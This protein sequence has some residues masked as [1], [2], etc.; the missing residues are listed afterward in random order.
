L[1]FRILLIVGSLVVCL[2]L[3]AGCAGDF[4]DSADDDTDVGNEPGDDD[5]DDDN[6]DDDNNDDN[7]DD[8]DD[9]TPPGCQSGEFFGFD[10]NPEARQTPFPSVLFT[11]PAADSP[12]GV[13]L[14]LGDHVTTFLEDGWQYSKWVLRRP[15]NELAG[16]SVSMPLWFPVTVRPDTSWANDEGEPSAGDPF[17]CAALMPEGH[18]EHGR[19]RSIGFEFVDELGVLAVRSQFALSEETTYACVA[20]TALTTKKGECYE[21]PPHLEYLLAGEPDPADPDF[22]LLE[23]ERLKLAPYVAALAAQYGVAA[24]E[25]VALTVFPTQ[26]ITHDLLSI[27][28]QLSELAATNPPTTTGEWTRTSGGDTNLDSVWDVEYD[29]VGWL[30]RGSFAYDA[31][32]DPRVGDAMPIVARLSVP[33]ATEAHP[34]PFPVVIY[35]HGINADRNQGHRFANTLAEQGIA[36]IAIDFMFHGARESIPEWVPENL[37]EVWRDLQFFNITAPDGVRDTFRQDVADLMWLR[38]LVENL[39]TLDLAPAATG[40]DGAPDLDTTRVFFASMSLGSMHGAILAPMEPGIDTFFFNAGAVNLERIALDGWY[41]NGIALVLQIAD[42]FVDAPLYEDFVMQAQMLF[43]VLDP[44]DGYAYAPYLFERPL[45][46]R[47]VEDLNVLHQ[48]A[49]YDNTLGGPGCAEMARSFGL[50]QIEP[51]V[52]AIPGLPQAEAPFVGPASFQFRTYD[53]PFL[54]K[55]DNVFFAAA[56]EQG[57]VF[58]TTA[59]ENG[60]ATVINPLE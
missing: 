35:A 6:N 34:G 4:E 57:A 58:F 27:G 19:V 36:M 8:N 59:Y 51:F 56:H 2:A 33:L 28:E 21:R 46:D 48:M 15:L 17:F 54:L 26:S 41:G 47:P 45:V 22:A 25:I 37:E 44:A 43:T 31:A 7:D 29:S 49:S 39:D 20:T 53:H 24:D 9:T 11:E 18:P 50:T 42:L 30:H 40:G 32:G 3:F 12:T 13:R 38:H 16:F 5:D 23:P 1:S 14:N 55:P 60:A 52:F 10:L